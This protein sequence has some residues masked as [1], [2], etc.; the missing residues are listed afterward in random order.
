[1]IAQL[2]V[3]TLIGSSAAVPNRNLDVVAKMEHFEGVA[4][5]DDGEIAYRETHEVETRN[6]RLVRS[7]TTYFDPEGRLLGTL[8]S[9]Y[10]Q[11]PFAP[12]YEFKNETGQV[13][14]GAEL[15]KD[16]IRLF[17][18]GQG[19]FL[20]FAGPR[21]EGLMGGERFVLGQG[22]HQ[23]ARARID[24]LARGE[25]LAVRFAIPSRFDSYVFR[26]EP[27]ETRDANVLRLRIGIDNW[28]LS[29]V[30]PSI[31]VDYDRVRKR[32]LTYRGVSNLT[33]SEG[34]SMQVTI[35]YSYP[36]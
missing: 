5:H 11:D 10:E 18:K 17:Y 32:L 1:M 7:L 25:R 22:L 14:E 13:V 24:D 19:R 6:G 33:N 30:A 12:N 20:P 3:L 8:L 35:R 26:I 27:I 29:L 9:D 21:E 34:E 2:V 36:T 23:L 16:G 15:K 28:I 4:Y 31:E